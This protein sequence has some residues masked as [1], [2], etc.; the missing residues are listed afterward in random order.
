[1]NWQTLLS[2]P[3]ISCLSRSL[4]VATNCHKDFHGASSDGFRVQLLHLNYSSN[5]DL[6]HSALKKLTEPPGW[7]LLHFHASH[8]WA[9]AQAPT[10][11]HSYVFIIRCFKGCS[12]V[13]EVRSAWLQVM[14]RLLASRSPA[15]VPGPARPPPAM[16]QVQGAPS[17]ELQWRTCSWVLLISTKSPLGPW[18]LWTHGTNRRIR[19]WSWRLVGSNI[20]A[21]ESLDWVLSHMMVASL[22]VTFWSSLCLE[23]N[24]G[25][26]QVGAIPSL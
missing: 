3:C 11:F 22:T 17:P 14:P 12:S 4:T 1:M 26:K 8:H 21:R 25:D 24:D 6:V 18:C 7:S 15:L 2:S 16:G 10:T 13:G 20:G 19:A 23:Y 9:S 5:L